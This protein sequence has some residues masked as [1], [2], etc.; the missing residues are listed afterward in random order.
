MRPEMIVLI[1]DFLSQKIS[2]KLP[3]E[4]FKTYF[5]SIS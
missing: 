5:D 2:E 1:G 4:S 3:Y